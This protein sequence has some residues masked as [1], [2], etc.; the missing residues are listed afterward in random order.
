MFRHPIAER[1]DLAA[2]ADYFGF[3]FCRI[4]GEKYWDE[5]AYY[6]FTLEQIE[7]DLEKPTNELEQMCLELV[8]KVVHDEYWLRKFAL[9]EQY[10]D[11][12]ATSWHNKEPSLYGRMDFSYHGNGPA[13]LLEY[14]A[15]T[16][17]SIYEAGFFQW[18]WL[19][20]QV[21][22]GKLPRQSDQFNSIQEALI[23]RFNF[24][25]NRELLH[26]VHSRDSIE[27]KGTVSY[28]QD[29]AYQAGIPTARM[30]IEDIGVDEHGQL[31]DL[32]HAPIAQLFKLY[33]WEELLHDDFAPHVLST[34]TLFVEPPWKA[35][36]SNKAI[37]PLLW[38][39]FPGHPN[40]LAAYFSGEEGDGLE[41]GFVNKPLF[42]REGENITW[43]HPDKG[44]VHQ[45]GSYGSEGFI[46]QALAPL[47]M[48]A[49]N[50]TLIGSWVVGHQSCGLTIRE[51]DGPITKDTS[52]FVPHTILG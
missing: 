22:R 41:Q 49:G 14:N 36:L 17:T 37:L 2:Q 27:D 40:L 52:R 42:S 43:V 35:V 29:C 4:D 31:T 30:A 45:S 46:T 39:M 13:K 28:L 3:D 10:W 51:D 15:D 33:P 8:D 16:P 20:Q 47:P 5:S 24:F 9:P 26:F 44:R 7:N 11:F 19:E 25:S 34:D 50:H 12:I 6:Q 23:E 48:F 32:E 1:P 38:Q 18:L 21:D